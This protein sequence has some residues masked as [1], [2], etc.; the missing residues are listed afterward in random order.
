MPCCSGYAEQGVTGTQRHV[1]LRPVA[2]I[3]RCCSGRARTGARGTERRARE[4]PRA[5]I[6]TCCSGPTRTDARGMRAR[7]TTRPRRRDLG[8]LQWARE[9]GCPWDSDTCALAARGGHLSVLQWA[10]ENGCEL[11]EKV[12]NEAAR[13]GAPRCVAMGEGTRMSVGSAHVLTCSGRRTPRS[14]AVGYS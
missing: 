12:C 7:A 9:N 5:G 6:S 4:Q 1:P 11:S 2:G 10:H 13:G 8:M 3:L 14:V